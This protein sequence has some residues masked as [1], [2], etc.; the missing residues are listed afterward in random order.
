MRLQT[1]ILTVLISWKCKCTVIISA[2]S[3][4]QENRDRQERREVKLKERRGKLS[5]QVTQSNSGNRLKFSGV[6]QLEQC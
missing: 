6:M 3:A 1:V 4:E 2:A 5:L